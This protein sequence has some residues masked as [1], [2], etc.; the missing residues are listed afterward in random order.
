[1][2]REMNIKIMR[3]LRLWIEG[4]G[5]LLLEREYDITNLKAV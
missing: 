5:N 3:Q 2:T 4:V 1:M